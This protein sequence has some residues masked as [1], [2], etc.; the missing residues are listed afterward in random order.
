MS[1]CRETDRHHL[2]DRVPIKLQAEVHPEGKLGLFL[3]YCGLFV[4]RFSCDLPAGPQTKTRHNVTG[5]DFIAALRTGLRSQS[6]GVLLLTT[7]F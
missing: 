5:T 4:N 1:V 2:G 7:S 3:G 6:W